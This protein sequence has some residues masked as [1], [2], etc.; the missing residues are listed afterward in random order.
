MHC[1]L[2][3]QAGIGWWTSL[4]LVQHTSRLS[5]NRALQGLQ[6]RSPALPARS[7]SADST[8]LPAQKQSH[9]LLILEEPWCTT[10]TAPPEDAGGR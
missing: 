2:H 5:L 7:A 9:R 1:Q 3:C 6:A 10:P 8:K 4:Y